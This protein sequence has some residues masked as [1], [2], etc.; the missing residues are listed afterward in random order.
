[1]MAD[2]VTDQ[3]TLREILKLYARYKCSVCGVDLYIAGKYNRQDCAAGGKSV[4]TSF[5]CH[6]CNQVMMPQYTEECKD[7]TSQVQ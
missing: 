4:V 5:Q 6:S 1:M 2:T 7:G 3:T